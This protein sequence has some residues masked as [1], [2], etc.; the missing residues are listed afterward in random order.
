MLA[1]R[2]S[3]SGRCLH[4]G[5]WL[6]AT[7]YSI[8]ERTVDQQDVAPGAPLPSASWFNGLK[9][10]LARRSDVDLAPPLQW[11]A[12]GRKRL[13]RFS[14]PRAIDIRLKGGGSGGVYPFEEVQ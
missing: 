9:R 4:A 12:A 11:Q 7:G 2:Y 6:L 14:W 10:R 8:R 3:T 5:Y 1:T 13:L